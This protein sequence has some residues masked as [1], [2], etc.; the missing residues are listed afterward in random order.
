MSRALK[1][2]RCGSFYQEAAGVVSIGDVSLTDKPD[3]DG[4]GA[5]VTCTAEIDLCV[6][7]GGAVLKALGKAWDCMA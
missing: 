5:T 7:C 1:C 2:D 3:T 6:T 4:N